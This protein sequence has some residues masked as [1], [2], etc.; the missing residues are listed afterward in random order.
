MSKETKNINSVRKKTASSFKMEWLH[1]I[2]ETATPISHKLINVQLKDIFC[3]ILSGIKCKY[4]VDAK[5]SGDFVS[6]KK[7]D[8]VWKLDFLKRH[9]VSK[10]HV[11]A[12]VKLRHQNS[13]LPATG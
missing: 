6:G 9:L 7:W 11:D 2:V 4:C 10:L 12:V 5:S 13:S 8:N 3:I 1:F